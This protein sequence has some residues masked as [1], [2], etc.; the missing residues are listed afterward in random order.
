MP[1]QQTIPIQNITNGDSQIT[2]IVLTLRQSC[3]TVVSKTYTEADA[4][5]TLTP[6]S[7]T[8]DSSFGD[9]N[10]ITGTIRVN[11][12]Y[13]GT[14]CSKTIN[15]KPNFT[16]PLRG[17]LKIRSGQSNAVIGNDDLGQYE[18]KQRSG[19][20]FSILTNVGTNAIRVK[21][22][23]ETTDPSLKFNFI[24]IT[25]PF[26]LQPFQTRKVYYQL[27]TNTGGSFSASYTVLWEDIDE[28]IEQSYIYTKNFS[29]RQPCVI[30][31]IE[32]RIDNNGA[33]NRWIEFASVAAK[34]IKLTSRNV[35]FI[36]IT[37]DPNGINQTITGN[38]SFGS[39]ART[40]TIADVERNSVWN[41]NNGLIIKEI[42]PKLS[43]YFRASLRTYQPIEISPGVFQVP[44]ALGVQDHIQNQRFK[45]SQAIE[46]IATVGSQ[47]FNSGVIATPLTTSST[48]GDGFAIKTPSGLNVGVFTQPTVTVSGTAPVE[49]S[50]TA[51]IYEVINFGLTAKVL[52]SAYIKNYFTITCP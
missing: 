9:C 2:G 38:V 19:S 34:T 15:F 31:S 43:K 51:K 46:I 35:K 11:V 6:T 18:L 30:N 17:V 28:Q 40:T 29:V 41:L 48:Y 45:P 13:E 16:P 3:P 25:T 5:I 22:V 36:G 50:V 49:I 10:N 37:G 1:V 26:I 24:N 20:L 47:T 21:S 44:V 27:D 39:I 32:V 12:L 52:V 42:I 14:V 8:I 23:I 7:I 33:G 4:E